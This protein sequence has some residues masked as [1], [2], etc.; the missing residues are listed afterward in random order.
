[1]DGRKLL[2]KS[3][4]GEVVKPLPHG[5]DPLLH[6]HDTEW[7]CFEGFDCPDLEDVARAEET[8]VEVLKK[9][10]HTQLKNRGL[11]VHA[12][13]VDG[14]G[15]RFKKCSST[16]ALAAKKASPGSKLYVV[17]DPLVAKQHRMLKAVPGEGM[18]TLRNPFVFGNLFLILSIEFPEC[19]PAESLN[20]LR[21]LLPPQP[22]TRTVRD[23][24]DSTELCT[25]SDI[26]PQA[27]QAANAAN[28]EPHRQAYDEEDNDHGMP[29]CQ[30]M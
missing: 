30:Q 3:S 14:N 15:A 25:L 16:E 10:C 22:N 7:E 11:D 27:S 21:Q 24:D 12:F 6:N 28:M 9:A 19:L 4:P 29:Q 2:I 23:E 13:V 20:A 5:F 17:A 8:D 1:M 18:P 26:D